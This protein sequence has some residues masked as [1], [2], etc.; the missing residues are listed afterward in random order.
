MVEKKKAGKKKRIKVRDLGK[1]KA[2]DLTEEQ[3]KGVSG[4]QK[5]IYDCPMDCTKLVVL[6]AVPDK[7]IVSISCPGDPGGG[8]LT[9]PISRKG[10]R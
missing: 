10:R 4:G 8:P 3:L 1:T 2:T 5:M 9:L 7:L 6:E